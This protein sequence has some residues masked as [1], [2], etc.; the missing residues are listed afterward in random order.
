MNYINNDD[1]NDANDAND[2]NEDR[3]LFLIHQAIETGDINLILNAITSYRN[4]INHT[5]IT[6]ANRIYEE[7]LNETFENINI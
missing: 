2:T 3:F 1:L 7:L 5:Y 6:M 4:I